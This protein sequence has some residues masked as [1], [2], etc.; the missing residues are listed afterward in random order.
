MY[1]LEAPGTRRQWL[2]SPKMFFDFL[3]FE[4]D[5]DHQVKYFVNKARHHLH[6]LAKDLFGIFQE[7]NAMTLSLGAISEHSESQLVLIYKKISLSHY[8]PYPKITNDLH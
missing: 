8:F 6:G 7:N 3:K 2:Q 5:L 4:A 1:C